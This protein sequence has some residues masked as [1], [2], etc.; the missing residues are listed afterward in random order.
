M[1]A[2]RG[3][4]TVS[5]MTTASTPLA[6]TLLANP[7]TRALGAFLGWFLYPLNFTLLILCFSGIASVGGRCA[8]GNTAY[9][10]K[11]QCPAGA[12]I[13]LPWVIFGMLIAVAIGFVLS[14][15]FGTPLAVWAWPILFCVL[16]IGFFGIGGVEGIIFGVA[17]IGGG[18]IPL[19]LELRGG[20]KRVFIGTN[21]LSGQQILERDGSKKGLLLR[22]TPNGD[23]AVSAG[24]ASWVLGPILFWIGA[25]GGIYLALV[26]FSAVAS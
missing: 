18:L 19:I 14:Q 2:G 13:F 11:T 7:V 9:V 5:V 24:I 25:L 20:V 12:T 3:A 23:G 15:G 10:I 4:N 26:W 21:T 17:F 6:R 16:G 1:D 8:S 22:A